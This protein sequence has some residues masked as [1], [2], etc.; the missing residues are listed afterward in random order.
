MISDTA[1]YII[2][3]LLLYMYF[4]LSR[5]KLM[6]CEYSVL[7]KDTEFKKRCHGCHV[8]ESPEVHEKM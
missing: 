3:L 1:T 7:R 6:V 8:R 5:E 2:Y 4:V